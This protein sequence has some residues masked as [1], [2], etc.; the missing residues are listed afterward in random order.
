MI[1]SLFTAITGLQGF[2]QMMNVVANNIANADTIGFKSSNTVFDTM[3]SQT[4]R[5]AGAPTA[6]NGGTDPNQV[7]LGVE[8]SQVSPIFSQGG[9]ETT[10]KPTDLMIQ[11]NGMF[12]LQGNSGL[13]YTRNGSFNLD[14]NGALVNPSTGMAV[15]GYQAQGNPPTINTNAPLAPITIPSSYSSYSIAPDGTVTGVSSSGTTTTLGQIAL[16][17]FP[18]PTGLQAIGNSLYIPTL[19]SGV[20]NISNATVLN[21][22]GGTAV[23]VISAGNSGV[24]SPS[25]T[26][27]ST[28]SVPATMTTTPT[29][30]SG[31]LSTGTLP[32]S[33]PVTSATLSFTMGTAGLSGTPT[34]TV[35]GVSVPVT[36]S[37]LAGGVYTFT[38]ANGALTL[39]L[40]S[41]VSLAPAS[42]TQTFTM[43]LGGSIGAAGVPGT[44]G[45]G[46]VTSGALEMSNVDLSREFSNMIIA[47]RGFEAN[48]K[49]ITTSDSIL[50]TLVNMK[51]LP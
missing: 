26:F 46:T 31:A 29:T 49:T 41:G 12:V 30:L 8:V 9:A 7:G 14:A 39:T 23:T 38:T 20:S 3:L 21:F 13:Y 33:Y 50:N 2:Q 16:A 40:P 45:I 4:I 18:N 48:S 44:N 32:Y 36:S 5:G 11:G 17:Q 15:I 34:I 6:A 35:N 24:N 47:E 43:N 10:G 1:G 22:G 28:M 42:G 51:Q 19:N 25:L 27:P 37:S